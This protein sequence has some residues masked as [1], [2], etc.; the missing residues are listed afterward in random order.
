MATIGFVGLGTM[1]L[2]MAKNLIK[3]GHKVIGLDF[4]EIAIKNE[5]EAANSAAEA[6]KNANFAITMLPMAKRQKKL[7][8][9]LM[10]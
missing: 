10:A 8:W 3:N 1:G 6:A 2:Y 9:D 4:S 5:G 7:F